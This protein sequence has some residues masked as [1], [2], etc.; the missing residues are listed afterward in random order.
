MIKYFRCPY[1]SPFKPGEHKSIPRTIGKYKVKIVHTNVLIFECQKCLKVFRAQMV[2]SPLLWA[3]LSYE[4]K[5]A[6]RNKKKWINKR[7]DNNA[8]KNEI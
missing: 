7:R 8:T 3:D 2:G 1:C 5:M 6:F 4:E